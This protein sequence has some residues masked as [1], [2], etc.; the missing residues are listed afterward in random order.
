MQLSFPKTPGSSNQ[1]SYSLSESHRGIRLSQSHRSA[2][3]KRSSPLSHIHVHHN[4]GVPADRVQ[5][6]SPTESACMGHE[7]T[8]INSGWKYEAL[9]P[10]N[11]DPPVAMAQSIPLMYDASIEKDLRVLSDYHVV[12]LVDDL[13][14]KVLRSTWTDV[15]PQ[16]FLKPS[17]MN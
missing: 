14:S 9:H 7:D 15:G 2:R 11:H 4:N 13:V 1:A 17:T 6:R 8:G 5:T 16:T 10:P 12:F 3:A